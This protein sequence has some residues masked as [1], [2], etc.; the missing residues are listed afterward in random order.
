[1]TT[2]DK[3]L[4]QPRLPAP[5]GLPRV[6]VRRMFRWCLAA[7]ALAVWPFLSAFPLF[8][9]LTSEPSAWLITT[10]SLLLATGFYAGLAAYIVYRLARFPGAAEMKRDGGLAIGLYAA[11]WTAAY[12]AIYLLPVLA[13]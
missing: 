13:R 3:M 5:T 9:M 1:M 12:M 11:A 7:P 4:A 8:E 10:R 2:Q 6:D